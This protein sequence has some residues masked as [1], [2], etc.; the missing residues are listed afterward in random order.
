MGLATTV[1]LLGIPGTI[2]AADRSSRVARWFDAHPD[3]AWIATLVLVSI[4]ILL[5]GIEKRGAWDGLI[6]DATNRKSLSR[7]QATVWGAL[8]VSGL[9]A[10]MAV[11]VARGC[12]D[13]DEGAFPD[14]CA[15]EPWE[16]ALSWPTLSLAILSGAV[17]VLAAAIDAAN[18]R[19]ALS[20]E[21][22]RAV[23]SAGLLA[24]QP[25]GGLA[26]VARDIK[27]EFRF[28]GVIAGHDD[29]R[30]SSWNDVAKGDIAQHVAYIDLARVQFLIATMVVSGMY[31]V[32]LQRELV[33]AS[34]PARFPAFSWEIVV[35]LGVS[36]A[37]YLLTKAI[38]GQAAGPLRASG[39][40]RAA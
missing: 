6:I 2:L 12:G 4:V 25:S 19:R 35:I 30:H 17:L 16:L 1:A 22:N 14:A 26:D 27:P 33:H 23:Q 15:V 34:G 38:R 37:A 40:G 28:F 29:P 36:A 8:F 18:G 21:A 24:S 20:A 32:F 10:A 9:S 3:G 39:S 11:N 7:L 13:P 31:A 5:L